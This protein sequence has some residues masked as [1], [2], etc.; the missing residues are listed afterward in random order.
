MAETP[1]MRESIE[2]LSARIHAQP[3]LNE[4]EKSELLGLLADVADEVGEAG[5]DSVRESVDLTAA[6]EPESV[7]EQL[8]NSLLELE[9]AFPRTASILGRIGDALGRMGI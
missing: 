7:P 5:H 9:S 3:H 8:E 4:A 2:K 6:V 1:A